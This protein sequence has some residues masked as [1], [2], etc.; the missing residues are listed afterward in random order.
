MPVTTRRA[1][2][3]LLHSA[4]RTSDTNSR[5]EQ[6]RSGKANRPTVKRARITRNG[7]SGDTGNPI[8]T[9]SVLLMLPLDIVLEIISLLKPLDLANLA[10]TNKAFRAMLMSPRACRTW[11][12]ARKLAG[13]APECPPRECR[14]ASVYNLVFALMRC[15]CQKCKEKR[16][17]N[18]NCLSE[19]FPDLNPTILELIP[20]TH[21]NSVHP[22]DKFYWDADIV[23]MA[24]RYDEY[25]RVIDAS[26]RKGAAKKALEQF[27]NERIEYVHAVI[28]HAENC[29][30]WLSDFEIYLDNERQERIQQYYTRI[31]WRFRELGYEDQDIHVIRSMPESMRDRNLT[32]RV[33][34][35][36]KPLLQPYIEIVRCSRL[37]ESQPQVIQARKALVNRAYDKYKETL[38]PIECV[39]LPPCELVHAIPAFRSLIYTNLDVAFQQAACDEATQ[40][41][42]EYIATFES[43]LKSRLLQ[44]MV[45]TGALKKPRKSKRLPKGTEGRLG[46]ATS[47]FCLTMDSK[48][49]ITVLVG[50]KGVAAHL[51]SHQQRRWKKH[52][53]AAFWAANTGSERVELDKTTLCHSRRGL[54]PDTAHPEDL[55]RLDKRFLCERCQSREWTATMASILPRDQ[56]CTWRRAVSH[57]TLMH[58][59]SDDGPAWRVLNEEEEAS[60][61]RG[62]LSR[63]LIDRKWRCTHCPVRLKF[64]GSHRDVL[65]HV[66]LFHHIAEPQEDV[67]FFH[68]CPALRYNIRPQSLSQCLA[69]ADG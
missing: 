49:D 31:V 57:D 53:K 69:A 48:H 20:H 38:R 55:D 8:S 65:Q 40:R 46:L 14:V 11:T 1:T 43:K 51:A 10:Q 25:Q 47:V 66:Q 6:S 2:Q 59:G 19:R 33:W 62:E 44:C 21:S 35:H 17:V 15:I 56:A 54:D 24:K 18:E 27:K 29:T 68:S 42:P 41:L 36:I 61:R 60:V 30:G 52:G 39:Y 5:G 16:L 28:E 63:G 67:D 26:S 50:L 23:A 32:E 45:D 22:M 64:S 13:N 34:K 4:E 9:L 37:D 12:T 58:S 3:R 7:G